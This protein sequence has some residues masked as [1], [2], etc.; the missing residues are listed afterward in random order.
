MHIWHEKHRSYSHICVEDANKVLGH[1]SISKWAVGATSVYL[2]Q[3]SKK[4]HPAV[5]VYC[6]GNTM[7]QCGIK[8]MGI[9]P[10]HLRKMPLKYWGMVPLQLPS[11]GHQGR[12]GELQ[13]GRNKIICRNLVHS[14]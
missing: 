12:G 2:A 14:T 7:G 5:S 6:N 1:A 8:N 9:V 3:A 10:M 13:N 11:A 4:T